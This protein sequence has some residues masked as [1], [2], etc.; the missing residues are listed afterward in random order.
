MESTRNRAAP[1][2]SGFPLVDLWGQSKTSK[3]TGTVTKVKDNISK[4]CG[5]RGAERPAEQNSWC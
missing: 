1:S 5:T 2:I 4:L 3:G